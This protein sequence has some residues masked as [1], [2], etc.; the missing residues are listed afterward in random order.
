MRL[1]AVLLLA[2]AAQGADLRYWV[3]PCTHSESGCKSDDPELAQWAMGSVG[4][5]LGRQ[6]APHPDTRQSASPAS[7]PVLGDRQQRTLRRN[8][9][10]RGQRRTRRGGVCAAHGSPARRERSAAARRHR[11]SDVRPR[12]GPRARARPHRE[13]RRHHVQLSVWR[14]YRGVLPGDIADCWNRAPTS[15]SIR[16]CRRRTGNG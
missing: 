11:V 15:T 7:P 12:N 14:R 9:H 8:A 6:T 2:A 16:E 1:L 3:E 10:D 5:R 13:L 4:V